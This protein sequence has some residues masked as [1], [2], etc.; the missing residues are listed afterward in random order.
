MRRK[1]ILGYKDNSPFKNEPYIDIEG[2]LITME[3][4]SQPLLAIPDNDQ[5]IIMKPGKKYKFPNSTKVREIPLYQDGGKITKTTAINQLRKKVGN[6][7]ISKEVPLGRSYY[8]AYTN[9]VNLNKPDDLIDELAHAYQNKYLNVDFSEMVFSDHDHESYV[10]P[11]TMEYGAHKEIKPYLVNAVNQSI[12]NNSSLRLP[13]IGKIKNSHR[14]FSSDNTYDLGNGVLAAIDPQNE[15][16]FYVRRGQ[17]GQYVYVDKSESAKNLDSPIIELM[18]KKLKGEMD[19]DSNVN[20]KGKKIKKQ[21]GGMASEVPVS[22]FINLKPFI[23]KYKLQY[24]GLIDYMQTLPIELQGQ[25]AQEFDSFD[26][27]TQKEVV[28]MLKGGYYQNGGNVVTPNAELEDGETFIQPDGE[29]QKIV[30]KKHSEGGEKVFL[31]DGTRIYSEYLKVPK[32]VAQEVLGKKPNKKYSYASLSKK[33]PTKPYMEIIEADEDDFKVEGAKINLM[34]NLS[35]LDTLFYAQEQDKVNSNQTKFQQGGTFEDY[36][37]GKVDGPARPTE[38]YGKGLYSVPFTVTPTTSTNVAP[39]PLTFYRPVVEEARPQVFDLVMPER[40]KNYELPE[41]EVVAKRI[42]NRSN[43]PDSRTKPIFNQPGVVAPDSD[44]MEVPL[45]FIPLPQRQPS[46][47]PLPIVESTRPTEQVAETIIESNDDQNYPGRKKWDWSKFGISNKLAGTIADI[48]LALGDKLTVR[49]PTL[50]N[51]QKTPLFTRFI[52]FDDQDV[53]RTFSLRSQQIQNSNMPEQ[54]KQAQLSALNSEYQDYQSKVDFTNLQR[55]EQKREMDI[56]KLQQYTDYNTDVKVEDQERYNEQRARVDFLRDQFKAQRKARIVNALRG[57][58]DYVDETRYKNQL[59]PNYK[60]NPITGNIGFREQP[61]SQLRSN[62]LSQY[63][64]R[65]QPKI[66]LGMGATAQQL[67]DIIII[68]DKDGK[69]S[70]VKAN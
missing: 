62:V 63:Q 9:S 43:K 29:L 50:Y 44:F 33:F 22:P 55:Y 8:N 25:F 52:D 15:E 56:N 10:T 34:N 21:L 3:G 18:K 30:G 57:Y 11:G 69:V 4:V 45:P 70:T 54:V 46:L 19:I 35:K 38:E 51:R 40:T 20:M 27:D 60:V 12:K 61:T 39:T 47:S 26:P 65:S 68:T 13:N 64:Q 1:S 17:D 7:T 6:P 28:K 14:Y 5:P 58:A 49:E 24:G 48:G 16:I 41:G 42:P 2:N 67:G 59:I 31:P 53:A 37:L 66:D 32:D 23:E 36:M